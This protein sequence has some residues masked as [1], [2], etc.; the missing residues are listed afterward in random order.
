MRLDP[1]C[2]R[3]ILFTV[4]ENTGYR[5]FMRYPKESQ[6]YEKLEKHP[7]ETVLYHIKQCEM[8]GL[9]TKVDWFLDGGC[10]I[11]DLTPYGHEFL[12]NIRSDT[13]WNKTKEVAQKVGSQS[14]QVLMQ[15][16]VN[17]ATALINK[18]F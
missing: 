15:V 9:L 14:L 6:T 18:H 3:D 13:N 11:Y 2:I 17:V 12:A 8:S 4:E 5:T 10:L 16:A 7:I 1:D